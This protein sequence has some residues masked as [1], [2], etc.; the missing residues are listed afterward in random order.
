LRIGEVD[1]GQA[2]ADRDPLRTGDQVGN[3]AVLQLLGSAERVDDD[4]VYAT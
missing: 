4:R 1:A 3:L 2:A